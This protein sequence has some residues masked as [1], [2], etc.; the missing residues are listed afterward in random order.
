MVPGFVAST[1]LGLGA[2]GAV[3]A[4]R[5]QITGDVV[6]LKIGRARAGDDAGSREADLLARLDNPHLIRL[7]RVIAM[8]DGATALVL[9]LAAGGSLAALVAARGPLEPGEVVTLLIPLARVLNELHAQGLVHGDLA[10]GNVLLSADGRPM[11]SDLGVSSIL[12][13]RPAREWSTPG[14]CDPA[15]G[16]DGRASDVWGLGA[17]G[18]FALTGEPPPG[19]HSF[20]SSPLGDDLPPA[21]RL[22]ISECLAAAPGARPVMA[23]M[24][25]RAWDAAPAVP[26]RLPRPA[27]KAG[28]SDAALLVPQPSPDPALRLVTSPSA[29][30]FDL[31]ESAQRRRAIRPTRLHLVAAIL[32]S[33][34]AGSAAAAFYATMQGGSPGSAAHEP[35]ATQTSVPPSVLTLLDRIAAARAAAFEQVSLSPLASADEPGSAAMRMDADLVHRLD[36]ADVRLDGVSYLIREVHA[37]AATDDFLDITALVTTSAH[38]QVATADGAPGSTVRRIAAVGPQSIRLRLVHTDAGAWLV[39]MVE[40][41]Q[42]PGSAT[43]SGQ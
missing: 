16:A 31:D 7:R 41:V 15:P 11:L 21:L 10:P 39:R 25:D 17:I 18:W 2:H 32:G 12:G 9:D 34:L 22:L 24:A 29:G 1:L 3:W 30:S 42:A 26:I 27:T 40:S 4:A 28:S 8:R 14:F 33:V 6:A 38:R 37:L 23:S 43:G 5:E 20:S 19:R 35:A 36:Q 13:S